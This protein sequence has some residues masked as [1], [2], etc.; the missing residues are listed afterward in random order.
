MSNTQVLSATHIGRDVPMAKA[1]LQILKKLMAYIEQPESGCWIWKGW[2]SRLGYG[3]VSVKG[4]AWP[5]HRLTY[6]LF[7]GEIPKGLQAC[8]TCDIPACCNPEHIFL[9]TAA[10][11]ARDAQSKGR[12]FTS[13]KTHCVR[14]HPLSGDNLYLA[15]SGRRQCKTCQLAK[16]RLDMGWPAEL[17]YTLPKQKLC[18]KLPGTGIGTGTP[19]KRGPTNRVKTHCKR[20]HEL[21]GD[22]LYVKPNGERQCRT[23]RRAVVCRIQAERTAHNGNGDA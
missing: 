11:N 4:R 8:H 5:V 1:R 9:G 3:S 21:A 19:I 10:D 22:N 13:S 16:C 20:G 18:R 15:P 17:A 7:K 12:H 2:C 6:T 23:C 14:G